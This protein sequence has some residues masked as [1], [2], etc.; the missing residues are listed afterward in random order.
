MIKLELTNVCV[1]YLSQL[2]PTDIPFDP[3]GLQHLLEYIRDAY[4]NPPVY[5]EENGHCCFASTLELHYHTV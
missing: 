2:V 4:G 3:A 1:W 5:I